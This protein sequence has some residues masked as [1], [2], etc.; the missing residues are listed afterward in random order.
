MLLLFNVL[1][2]NLDKHHKEKCIECI[3]KV[4]SVYTA[5]SARTNGIKHI[6]WSLR[7]P[8]HSQSRSINLG[9]SPKSLDRNAHPGLHEAM[10]S[11]IYNLQRDELATDEKNNKDGRGRRQWIG[12]QA[13]LA[14]DQA[15][16]YCTIGSA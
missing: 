10:S 7:A 13:R 15:E 4:E 1:S 3:Y 16:C 12:A 11:S 5:S 8:F 9:D 2:N 14:V 6:R